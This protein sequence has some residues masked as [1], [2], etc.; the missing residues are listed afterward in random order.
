MRELRAFKQLYDELRG[1]YDSLSR[2]DEWFEE[3]YLREY[4]NLQRI[5][6]NHDGPELPIKHDLTQELV[7]YGLDLLVKMES[8]LNIISR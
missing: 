5:L 6:R 3:D 2:K 7:D 8:D 4:T 1:R